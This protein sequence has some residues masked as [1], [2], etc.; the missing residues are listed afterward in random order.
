MLNFTEINC[1]ALFFSICL[2]VPNGKKQ[3]GIT[4]FTGSV[5]IHPDQEYDPSAFSPDEEI[6]SF[7]FSPTPVAQA[8]HLAYHPNTCC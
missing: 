3:Y 5:P 4:V 7:A 6:R 2:E 1:F 8:F